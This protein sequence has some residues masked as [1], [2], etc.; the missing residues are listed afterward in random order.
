LSLQRSL[1]PLIV[2]S[3]FSSVSSC[4][5]HSWWGRKGML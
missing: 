2:S 5:Y 1:S 4:R 3:V